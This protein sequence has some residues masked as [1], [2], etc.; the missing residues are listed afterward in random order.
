MK[1][2][3]APTSSSCSTP[4][5]H[6]APVRLSS[7]R[8]AVRRRTEGSTSSLM[9]WAY[10]DSSGLR[11]SWKEL[12]GSKRYPGST[13]TNRVPAPVWMRSSTDMASSARRLTSTARCA[14]S[15][16]ARRT[17][18]SPGSTMTRWPSPAA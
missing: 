13:R 17:S 6:R 11:G 1:R 12:R 10:G 8:A 7:P 9:C 4:D 5:S 14:G 15:E 16:D 2:E 3:R 18:R